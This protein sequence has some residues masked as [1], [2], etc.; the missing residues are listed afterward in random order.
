MKTK[1]S[2]AVD[3][4]QAFLNKC[5]THGIDSETLT[6]AMREVMGEVEA[7]KTFDFPPTKEVFT[8]PHTHIAVNDT[9]YH[10]MLQSLQT[11]ASTTLADNGLH[12]LLKRVEGSEMTCFEFPVYKPALLS[13]S[14]QKAVLSNPV[15]IS[16][17]MDHHDNQQCEADSIGIGTTG[18]KTRFEELKKIGFNVM[19]EDPDIWPEEEYRKTFGLEK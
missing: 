17:L 4:F 16:A 18:N 7:R 2:L 11:I 14:E 13:E 15:M 1:H 3:A 9:D 12:G 8:L 19:Q 6:A 10:E 5:R